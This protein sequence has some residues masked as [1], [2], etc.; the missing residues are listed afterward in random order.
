MNELR[1]S[2]VNTQVCHDITGTNVLHLA[3]EKRYKEMV[4]AL[5]KNGFDLNQQK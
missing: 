1:S 3:V 2:G 4:I 5:I